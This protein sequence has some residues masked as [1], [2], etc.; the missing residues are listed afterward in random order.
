MKIKQPAAVEMMAE[1]ICEKTNKCNVGVY[2]LPNII[3]CSG[4]TY[5]G[6]A[7]FNIESKSFKFFTAK[8]YD[9]MTAGRTDE[10]YDQVEVVQF[11]KQLNE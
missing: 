10:V 4:N 2:E 7:I 6:L 3:M 1:Y 5:C 9:A 8:T 11:V